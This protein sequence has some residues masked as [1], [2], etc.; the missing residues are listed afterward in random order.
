M[1]ISA[2]ILLAQSN[3]PNCQGNDIS[4]WSHCQGT[5]FFGTTDKYV[6]DFV[7]GRSEGRG[8]YTSITGTTYIGQWRNGMFDGEGVL[9]HTDGRPSQSGIWRNGNFVQNSEENNRLS[10]NL[11]AAQNKCKDLGFKPKTE[12]FGKCVLQLSK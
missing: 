9:S 10:K 11:Q 6:G 7:S 12:G 3:L 4:K 2:E 8:V 1:L 5:E